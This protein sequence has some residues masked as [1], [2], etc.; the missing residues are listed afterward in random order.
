[1]T[2]T[3]T[4]SVSPDYVPDE[5]DLDDSI[6]DG[7]D[8]DLAVFEVDGAALADME[9][10]ADRML[11]RLRRSQAEVARIRAQATRQ[12]TR[13][14]TWERRRT[15]VIT[16]S[17][18]RL[19]GL[20]DGLTRAYHARTTKVTLPLSNG[21]LKLRPG[22]PAITCSNPAAFWLWAHEERHPTWATYEIVYKPDGGL[23]H[24]LKPGALLGPSI[25]P[26]SGQIIPDLFDHA[27]IDPETGEA[28]P[29][30]ILRLAGR[31]KFSHTTAGPV[32]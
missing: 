14:D 1:M 30:L 21:V 26:K 11:Y 5:D 6:E 16:G 15:G 29:Y 28:V 10:V 2:D 9:D 7:L 19:V 17:M 32:E 12:R 3:A 20:L 27:A 25:D 18:D 8:D 31:R 24:K 23:R 4:T 22:Q 13:I